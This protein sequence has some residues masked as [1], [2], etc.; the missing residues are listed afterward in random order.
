MQVSTPPAARRH[1]S[2][3]SIY[4]SKIYA[5]CTATA[6]C[7]LP[8][9]HAQ[10]AYAAALR[11]KIYTLYCAT[12]NTSSSSK[13]RQRVCAQGGAR[14]ATSKEAPCHHSCRNTRPRPAP[15]EHYV[16]PPRR[17]HHCARRNGTAHGEHRR[18]IAAPFPTQLHYARYAYVFWSPGTRS[19]YSLTMSS[20]MHFLICL[21]ST[22]K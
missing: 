19:R 22:R 12:Y 15:I 14:G 4:C 18:A 10:Y 9:S 1:Y 3:T 16:P 2:V 21:G 6:T 5:V 13:G 17:D 7:P 8:L 11:Y 20:S